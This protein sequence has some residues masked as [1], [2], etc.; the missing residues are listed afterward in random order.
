MSQRTLSIPSPGLLE[1]GE[2]CI[3][4]STC[5]WADTIRFYNIVFY[6]ILLSVIIG[7]VIGFIARKVL[8]FA[9]NK[10]YVTS[11]EKTQAHSA[12]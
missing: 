9:H 1:N 5:V 6:Q 7:A 3:W 11:S 2:W 12:A 8:F 10:G 4:V